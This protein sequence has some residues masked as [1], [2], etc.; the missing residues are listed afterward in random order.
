IPWDQITLKMLY[1]NWYGYAVGENMWEQDSGWVIWDDRQG[2]IKVRKARRFGFD[3]EKRLRLLTWLDQ[4]KGEPLQLD[5]FW[6]YSC[7]ADNDDEPHGQGWAKWCL[8][9]IM[10]KRHGFQFWLK[11]LE[12]CGVPARIGKYPEGTPKNEQDKLLNAVASLSSASASIVPQGMIVDLI[13]RTGGGMP[14]N[15]RLVEAC[16]AEIAKVILGQTLTTE[17][18]G[19][20]Y[21]AEVQFDVRQALSKTISDQQCHSFMYGPLATLIRYNQSRL[22]DVAIPIIERNFEQEPDR[23]KL[24][25]LYKTLNEIGFEVDEETIQ[26]EFGDGVTKKPEPPPGTMLPGSP[27]FPRIAINENGDGNAAK[28][29]ITKNGAKN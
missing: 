6:V 14:D 9:P 27:A 26:E 10:F 17:A 19:G 7:G 8:W 18:V 12:V 11:F 21:K 28:D 4:W 5:K 1:A 22:G 15:G 16:D 13:E 20:Q 23:N 24:A 2:G 29:P 3:I 25:D